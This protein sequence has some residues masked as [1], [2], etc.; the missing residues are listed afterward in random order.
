MKPK[1][2]ILLIGG[3]EQR[4]DEAPDIEQDESNFN[5]YEIFK[6][7]LKATPSKHIVFITAGKDLH[8]ETRKN[9]TNAFKKMG[10]K[11]IDFMFIEKRENAENEKYLQKIKSAGVIFFTGG[12]Q[13]Y[14][15][16]LLGGTSFIKA[17]KEKYFHTKNFIVA[18]TSAGAMVIPSVMI[19]S[20]GQ[21]EA[22]LH[23]NLAISSGFS[24]LPECIVDTHF[25]KRGRFS[26]LAHAILLNPE[27][28][29]IGLGEDSAVLI[30]QGNEVECV[31]SGMVVIIDGS[32]IKQTNIT[33]VKEGEP[34]YL[35]NIKAYFLVRKCKFLLKEHKFIPPK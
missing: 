20:G 14:H 29:G 8:K 27:K 12:D 18:G 4:A 15:A 34:I 24:L 1:G 30:R 28:L 6:E 10:F 7:I 9:Y 2:I 13:F 32:E 16:T 23:Q 25:I 19:A 26:R 22:L 33:E 21:T 5:P 3:A 17:I 35:D 31:G 11:T